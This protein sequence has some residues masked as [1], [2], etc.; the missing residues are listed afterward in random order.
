MY[1]CDAVSIGNQPFWWASIVPTHLRPLSW[2]RIV[3][4][5][6]MYGHRIFFKKMLTRFLAIQC[7]YVCVC[8]CMYVPP[9]I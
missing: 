5:K 4:L 8:V 2:G 6:C 9:V 7:V 3:T 1:V